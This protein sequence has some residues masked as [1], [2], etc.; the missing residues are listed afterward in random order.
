MKV[1][2]KENRAIHAKYMIFEGFFQSALICPILTLFEKKYF[3]KCVVT[4]PF[5]SKCYF[6]IPNDSTKIVFVRKYHIFVF[7]KCIT[8]LIRII[9]T[10]VLYIKNILIFFDVNVNI[11]SNV[12][13]SQTHNE[14]INIQHARRE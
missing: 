12:K 1:L 14:C 8:F 10:C 13:R 6:L 4:G 2:N 5:R 7:I 3:Y 11:I 9:I